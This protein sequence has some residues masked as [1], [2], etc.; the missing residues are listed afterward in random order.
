M[1]CVTLGFDF[2]YRAKVSSV[3]DQGQ[4]RGSSEAEE[5]VCTVHAPWGVPAL[6]T[7]WGAPALFIPDCALI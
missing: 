5:D 2:P 6:C 3:K 4:P 1:H 7:P